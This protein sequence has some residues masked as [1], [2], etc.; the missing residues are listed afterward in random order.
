MK[1][2]FVSCGL[3]GKIVFRDLEKK[4][5][6]WIIEPRDYEGD[7]EY[8]EFS[9]DSK[10]LLGSGGHSNVILIDSASGASNT[11]FHEKGI[12]L[13]GKMAT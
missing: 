12:V 9:Y 5:P 4:D 2:N 7:V 8:L 6:N 13:K 3:D 1:E 11:I 10:K